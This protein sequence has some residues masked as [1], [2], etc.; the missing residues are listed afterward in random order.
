M[1]KDDSGDACV[2]SQ[3][4]G[5]Q[6]KVALLRFTADGFDDRRLQCQTGGE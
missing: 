1:G 4:V 2:R 6:R 5:R 3:R